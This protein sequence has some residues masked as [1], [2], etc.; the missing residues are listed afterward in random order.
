V[1]ADFVLNFGP[2][3]I[4]MSLEFDITMHET[5]RA[6]PESRQRPRTSSRP[7]NESPDDASSPIST[8]MPNALPPWQ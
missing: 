7:R 5:R 3:H 1:N 4:E 8:V 2:T 6:F